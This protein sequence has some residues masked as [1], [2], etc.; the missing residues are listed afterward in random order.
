M[1]LLLHLF[2]TTTRNFRV[3]QQS[4]IDALARD[5][6]MNLPLSFFGSKADSTGRLFKQVVQ[7]VAKNHPQGNDYVAGVVAGPIS[8][9]VRK[10][11]GDLEKIQEDHVRQKRLES[12]GIH[13]FRFSDHDVKNNMDGVLKRIES[14]IE[15][16]EK[17]KS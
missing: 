1:P 9:A 5:P 4:A 10:L 11:S 3:S 16:F 7:Y 13:F 15:D 8:F 17:S 2:N 6:A 12:F 14:W